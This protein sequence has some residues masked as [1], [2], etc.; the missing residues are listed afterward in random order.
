M[1]C[2]A[3]TAPPYTCTDPGTYD[4]TLK[5]YFIEG[6]LDTI[7]LNYNDYITVYPS[8]TSAFIADPLRP[9]MQAT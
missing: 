4:L 2:S 6:C 3:T 8:P 1:E 7:T 9:F 5:V